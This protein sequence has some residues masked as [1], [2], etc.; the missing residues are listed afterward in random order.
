MSST[1]GVESD[2]SLASLFVSGLGDRGI[3]GPKAPQSKMPW[4]AS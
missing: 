1:L 2:M 4:L 3:S